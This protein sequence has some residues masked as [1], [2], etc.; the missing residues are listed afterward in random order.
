MTGV[1]YAV[2]MDTL[3]KLLAGY[4]PP[5][6]EQRQT[7]PATVVNNN[8]VHEEDEDGATTPFAAGN[9]PELIVE[10]SEYDGTEQA[11]LATVDKLI[12]SPAQ[13]VVRGMDIATEGAQVLLKRAQMTAAKRV[14]EFLFT[15]TSGLAQYVPL[16]VVGQLGTEAQRCGGPVEVD[17]RL[18]P[19]VLTAETGDALETVVNPLKKLANVG[20]SL[21]QS[22]VD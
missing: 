4:E 10:L 22:L 15:A 21:S 14:Q 8:P 5:A 3:K 17:F 20:G 1:N 12:G 2:I 7:E 11:E 6:E 16:P 18:P 9:R 13:V 19:N